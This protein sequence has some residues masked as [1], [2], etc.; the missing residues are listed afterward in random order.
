MNGQPKDKKVLSSKF[1]A[2]IFCCLL[3]KTVLPKL[4]ER[5]YG[6]VGLRSYVLVLYK[7]RHGDCKKG[8][9]VR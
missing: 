7:L 2:N 4:Y 8:P 3:G 5:I 1:S 9:I 6:N